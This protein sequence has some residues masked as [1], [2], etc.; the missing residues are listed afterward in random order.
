MFGMS[1]IKRLFSYANTNHLLS[2]LSFLLENSVH[3]S[4][5][6]SNV[7]DVVVW[8]SYFDTDLLLSI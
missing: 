2:T 4:V 6:G 1:Q 5:V 8:F 7:L 3:S